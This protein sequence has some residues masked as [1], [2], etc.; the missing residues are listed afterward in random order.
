ML[1]A[2]AW[3]VGPEKDSSSLTG[4]VQHAKEEARLHGIL[5]VLRQRQLQVHWR[6][7]LPSED[8]FPAPALSQS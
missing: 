2:V 7:N 8:Q 3:M 1:L 4:R 6:I 5:F